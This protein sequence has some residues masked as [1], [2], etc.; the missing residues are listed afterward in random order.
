MGARVKRTS[1]KVAF[2]AMSSS[3]LLWNLQLTSSGSMNAQNSCSVNNGTPLV[4]VVVTSE[5]VPFTWFS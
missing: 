4:R 5:L 3:R 1:P 2:S